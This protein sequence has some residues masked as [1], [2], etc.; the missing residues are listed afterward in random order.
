MESLRVLYVDVKLKRTVIHSFLFFQRRVLAAGSLAFL[1][2]TN[3]KRCERILANNS[4]IKA[5]QEAS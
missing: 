5:T 2:P 4:V 1:L 3:E